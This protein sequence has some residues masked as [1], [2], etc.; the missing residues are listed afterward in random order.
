MIA[1]PSYEELVEEAQTIVKNETGITNF[2]ESSV[3]GSLIKIASARVIDLYHQLLDIYNQGNLSTATGTNLDN[4]GELFGIKRLPAKAA[5]T[6]GMGAAVQFRNNS[7]TS[8]TI[9][10]LTRIWSEAD[11]RVAFS[12]NDAL[13]LASGADGYIDI[14]ALGDG[15]G[16]NVGIGAI[17]KHDLGNALVT[18][19]NI[20]PVVNGTAVESDDNYRYR[21]SKAFSIIQG[22]TEESIRMKLMEIP[23][24]KDVFPL[25]LARGTGTIDVI[26]T[27]VDTRVSQALLDQAQS[28][29]D[30]TVA[31]GISAI[32]KSPKEIPIDLTIK[33]SL[34]DTLDS[35]TAGSLVAAAAAAYIDNLPVGDGIGIGSFIFYELVSRLM[36]AHSDI[37]NVSV[38]IK[39]N[40]QAALNVDQ[41][42]NKGDKFFLR[43]PIS[44]I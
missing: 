13:T 24:V 15:S 43:K 21:I 7:D 34:K 25:P 19:T 18:V 22:A 28:V 44:I 36:D 8:V 41:Y 27:S 33:L 2:S 30:N 31:F 29:L 35:A 37:R 1:I 10:A 3:A 11:P 9:P 16:Y 40:G 20:L 14:T 39:V 38:V 17:S 6:A 23:G 32:A 5:T 42:A 4:I 12:T 26:I